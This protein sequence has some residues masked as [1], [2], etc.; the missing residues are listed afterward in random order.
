MPKK[1]LA[2]GPRKTSASSWSTVKPRNT[3][4][5]AELMAKCA[6]TCFLRPHDLG[7][8]ICPRCN[9]PY[10]QRCLNHDPSL[11]GRCCQVDCQGL[12][13]A[14][15]RAAQYGYQD[16]VKKA[17][18]LAKSRGWITKREKRSRQRLKDDTDDRIITCPNY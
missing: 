17:N 12:L 1:K 2:K 14:K 6:E 5:R 4:E 8:P 15:R 11:K 9:D 18:K 13:A 3:K 16:I 7:F 10:C